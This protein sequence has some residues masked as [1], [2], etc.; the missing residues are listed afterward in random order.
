LIVARRKQQRHR[1]RIRERGSLIVETLVVVPLLIALCGI[2]FWFYEVHTAQMKVYRTA[3]ESVWAT[4]TFGCGQAGETGR[5]M[6]GPQSGTSVGGGGPPQI[7][8]D[9]SQ[10][11]RSVPGGPNNE[12]ITRS[13]S[14]GN[15]SAQE[16]V[17]G[18]K[19]VWFEPR[20]TNY[21]ASA[22]MQCNEAVHDGQPDPA[23]R[24]AAAAFSP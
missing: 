19:V 8:A 20:T 22:S 16:R 7:P 13:M 10:V 11:Y 12:V 5:S 17:A 6:P 15:G 3:R 14:E 1:R 23:K 18:F 4:A 9:F 21:N 2:G 24:I